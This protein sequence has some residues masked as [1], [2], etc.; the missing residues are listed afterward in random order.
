[1]T[2]QYTAHVGNDPINSSVTKYAK[3]A[4][5]AAKAARSY[6]EFEEIITVI[7]PKGGKTY[8]K[9]VGAGVMADVWKVKQ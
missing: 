5:A 3:S 9:A 7:G 4:E 1:M 8:W 2:T 6:A